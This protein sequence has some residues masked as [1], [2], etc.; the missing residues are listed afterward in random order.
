M[1][2]IDALTKRLR[3]GRAH[4]FALATLAAV[5]L[6]AIGLSEISWAPFFFAAVSAA[7]PGGC[8]TRIRGARL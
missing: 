2:V 6:W 3:S 1:P 4:G 8:L 5:G 7:T